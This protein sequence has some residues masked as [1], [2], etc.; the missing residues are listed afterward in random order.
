[1]GCCDRMGG[2]LVGRWSGLWRGGDEA[3]FMGDLGAVLLVVVLS[4]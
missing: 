4:L 2:C 3:V 1:M